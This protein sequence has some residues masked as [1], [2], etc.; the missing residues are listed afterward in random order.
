MGLYLER[1]KGIDGNQERLSGSGAFYSK[2]IGEKI[3]PTAAVS[4]SFHI[5]RKW[6][7]PE[8]L[9]RDR[10]LEEIMDYRDT[11]ARFIRHRIRSSDLFYPESSLSK[12]KLA[13]VRPNSRSFFLS[14]NSAFF[15]SHLASQLGRTQLQF[16]FDDLVI[17][18]TVSEIS[19]TA[20][21]ITNRFFQ[22]IFLHVKSLASRNAELLTKG[23]SSKRCPTH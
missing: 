18:E 20:L 9:G 4:L 22:A 13:V 6:S 8:P 16:L 21:G 17:A 3:F 2:K 5:Y 14:G 7:S 1:G 11:R 10:T 19:T 15:V 12:Y 23:K